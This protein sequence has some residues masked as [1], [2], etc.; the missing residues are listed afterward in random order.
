MVRASRDPQ[1]VPIEGASSEQMMN[2]LFDQPAISLTGRA[3]GHGELG[4]ALGPVLL[5]ER[6]RA[7][8]ARLKRLLDREGLVVEAVASVERAEAL[9]QRSQFALV[10]VGF[11][12]DD[13]AVAAWI[14]HFLQQEDA[15]TVVA[16]GDASRGDSPIAAMRAGAADFLPRPV[17]AD[18]M[19]EAA[20]RCLARVTSRDGAPGGR[21][22]A[23][24]S[25]C[26]D[27]L[28]GCSVATKGL[29]EIL[30]RVAPTPSTVLIEGESGTGKEVIARC[31]HA[32]SGRRGQFVPVNCG[33]IPEDL[34]ESELF[35]HVRGAFTGAQG[36]RE[37]LFVHANGGTVFLDEIGEMPLGMQA[38]LLRVLEEGCVRP[39]GSDRPVPIDVRILAASNRS[40]SEAIAHG[41]LREDLYYRLNVLTLSIPPLRDRR[42]DVEELAQY[43]VARLGRELGLPAAELD[44]VE[45]E[46]LGAYPWP[47]NVRELRNALERSLLLGIK[48]SECLG[49]TLGVDLGSGKPSSSSLEYPKELP[50]SAVEKRHILAVLD[51]VEGNKSE[52]ARRLEI[53]RKTLERKLRLW[54]E[55]R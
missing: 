18:R 52:A 15:V 11:E 3:I 21:P 41:R 12:H 25:Q 27:R 13:V 40:L 17:S 8:R 37:G 53:S 45:L 35:G 31:I 14:R 19:C 16:Y 20:K 6:D 50:L 49:Q 30:R 22:A 4:R 7:E 1:V 2:K 36:S 26:V 23:R 5:I 38:K 9:R 55:S 46:K 48:P 33:A 29:V 42:E 51:G 44:A 54:G 43:F 10:L 28:V 34:L 47:G 24:A 39:V 32:G